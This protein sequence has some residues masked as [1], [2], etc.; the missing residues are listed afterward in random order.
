MRYKGE[1]NQG[2]VTI[3]TRSGNLDRPQKN[4]SAWAP[5]DQGARTVSPSARFLQ[6]RV[7][8]KAGPQGSSPE[9]REIE[10]AYMPKNV[11]PIIE[12]DRYH[13]G[14]LSVPGAD[15]PTDSDQY[16]HTH[17]AWTTETGHRSHRFPSR[18]SPQVKQ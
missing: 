1:L 16:H 4:W 13:S 11:A 18:E 14:K 10:L 3:E 6:Y 12:E 2:T 8:L 5:L 7:T 17:A 9:L 15:T